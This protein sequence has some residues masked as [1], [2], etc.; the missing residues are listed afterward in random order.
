MRIQ[1]LVEIIVGIHLK[2]VE[3]PGLSEDLIGLCF[4]LDL[5][6]GGLELRVMD[7]RVI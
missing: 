3:V 6:S 2:I 5:L 4:C 1:M 7:S